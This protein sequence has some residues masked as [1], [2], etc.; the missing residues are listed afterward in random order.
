ML[1]ISD[2]RLRCS[3]IL[4]CFQVFH[5]V[6]GERGKALV[7]LMSTWVAEYSLPQVK[8]ATNFVYFQ[9]NSSAIP[10]DASVLFFVTKPTLRNL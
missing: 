4:H 5:H 9:Y 10:V 7:R 6:K 1:P 2:S 8:T 3:A